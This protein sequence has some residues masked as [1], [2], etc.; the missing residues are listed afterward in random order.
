M[1][2]LLI[3]TTVFVIASAILILATRT[4]V[5]KFANNRKKVPTNVYSII[6]Q[7][8]LVVEDI[9]SIEGTGQVK[10][11]GELWSAICTGNNTIS[12]GTTIKVLEVQ[13]VKL[14]VEPA[15]KSAN[16]N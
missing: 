14:L 15:V 7:E 3:Q 10:I 6:N 16:I 2:W 5:D 1:Q 8:G 13:G 9:N 4:F 12:K 11:N